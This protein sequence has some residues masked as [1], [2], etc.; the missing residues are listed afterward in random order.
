MSGMG[1]KDLI[2]FRDGGVSLWKDA[3]GIFL[4]ASSPPHWKA[5]QLSSVI[6][7]KREGGGQLSSSSSNMEPSHMGSES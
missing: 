5:S 6:A 3:E 2:S 4:P 1:L 7:A